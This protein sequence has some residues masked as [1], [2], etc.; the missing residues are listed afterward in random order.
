LTV[1]F[2]GVVAVS[3]LDLQAPLGRITGLIG[4]NGAGKT[5]TFNACSGLLRPGQGVV[6]YD[7]RDISRL[8][9]ARRARLGIGRTF[10]TAELWDSLSVLENVELGSEA[11][12]A[13]T[14]VVSQI[15]PRPG[16]RAR[17]AAAAREAI[18][19]AGIADLAERR[20]GDLS[21]G[22]R[23]LVELARVLAGPFDLLLLDEPSSGLDKHETEQF[24]AVLRRVVAERGTGVLLVE[25]DMRLVMALCEY[26]YV[27][28]FG[29]RIFD[30]TAA[31]V[32][33]SEIVRQAY[34]G[35]EVLT[36][37]A[38]GEPSTS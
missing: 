4:P 15:L 5:T 9:V 37:G 35:S 11:P 18:G 22:Q 25:H 3:S 19:L 8:P 6:R 13:G 12:L 23:R 10:Q 17:V 26:I 7:G 36:V 16:D 30:G 14:N 33:S 20:V 2:G 34:L 27:M 38:D 21:T 28:D 32:A 31:E 1:R 29:R 24:A